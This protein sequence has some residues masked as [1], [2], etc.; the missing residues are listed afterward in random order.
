MSHHSEKKP[1][2]GDLLKIL[3]SDLAIQTAACQLGTV[4]THTDGSLDEHDL[5]DLEFTVCSFTGRV[6]VNFGRPVS[7]VAFTQAQARELAMVLRTTAKK[8][9]HDME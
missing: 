8:A 7:W 3:E 1:I 4:G 5:G 2:D 6:V 9:K